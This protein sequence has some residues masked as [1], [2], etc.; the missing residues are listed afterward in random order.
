MTDKYN[1]CA[2]S[3]G[4]LPPCLLAA[5]LPPDLSKW[6]KTPFYSAVFRVT[7]LKRGE[8]NSIYLLQLIKIK[9]TL[10]F[11]LR[12][13]LWWMV[14]EGLASLFGP[15]FC[16]HQLGGWLGVWGGGVV[17]HFLWAETPHQVL[18]SLLS[19]L[20]SSVYP[21]SLAN[22]RV[23]SRLVFLPSHLSSVLLPGFFFVTPA[24][25]TEKREGRGEGRVTDVVTMATASQSFA[26][27]L[28]LS[29]CLLFPCLH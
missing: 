16:C 5:A 28:S 4:A 24:R 15:T 19:C 2:G 10:L 6:L 25:A 17:W 23:S 3:S 21:W 11:Q 18:S 8:A 22:P 26:G 9:P 20:I 27:P 7:A 14:Q 29:S 1:C 13:R 12:I